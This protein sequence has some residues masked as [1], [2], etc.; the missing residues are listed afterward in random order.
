MPSIALALLLAASPGASATTVTVEVASKPAELRRG[1]QGHE[2]LAEGKG[3]LFVLPKAE[4]ARFW[5][6]E[7]AFDIDILF[8]RADGTVANVAARVPPCLP[9]QRSEGGA[10]TECPVYQSRGKVTHVLEVPAGW[11]ERYGVGA[12]TRLQIDVLERRVSTASPVQ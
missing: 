9:S 10:Q 4:I 1:L 8:L 7:M 11:S 5:M 3:M 2:P 6:K 12:G